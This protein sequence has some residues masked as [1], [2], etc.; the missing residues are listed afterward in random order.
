M[1]GLSGARPETIVRYLP[2]IFDSIIQLMVQPPRLS[3]HTLNIGNICFEAI[4]LLLE[5]IAV[6]IFLFFFI[7][8]VYK[9]NFSLL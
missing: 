4:C 6:S 9:Y 3:G 5:N 2:L 7:K 8:N 1:L